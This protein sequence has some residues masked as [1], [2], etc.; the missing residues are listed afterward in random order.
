MLLNIY[1]VILIVFLLVSC[2]KTH[3]KTI[4]DYYKQRVSLFKE[5][6]CKDKVAIIGNSLVDNA[7]WHE[8][9]GS[10]VVNR[11]IG[12][13]ITS[14]LL[15]RIDDIIEQEPKSIFLM[16]GIN[17]IRGSLPVKRNYTFIID[18]ITASEIPLFVQ[19]TLYVS[20]DYP[21]AHR[22]NKKVKDLNDYLKDIEGITY[23]KMNL[24]D[25]LS[26]DNLHLTGEGYIVWADAIKE[27]L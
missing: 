20:D 23:I 8:L 13:E 12:G 2:G 7:E 17:D 10:G 15:L 21:N 22:I 26:K 5:L 11:G 1:Y 19:S 27:Y 4:S 3:Q 6:S 24:K 9:L 16:T 25:Y 14:E 18:K